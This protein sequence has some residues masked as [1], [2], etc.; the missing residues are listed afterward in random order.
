MPIPEFDALRHEN[1]LY[2]TTVGRKTGKPRTIEIWFVSYEERL[3]LL[4]EHGLKAQW[5]RNIQANPDVRM[6]IARHRFRARGR[7]L[8]AAQDEN[9]VGAT[10]CRSHSM[11]VRNRDWRIASGAG[12]PRKQIERGDSAARVSSPEEPLK[13]PEAFSGT[14]M[15]IAQ[16]AMNAG[17]TEILCV[18]IDRRDTWGASTTMWRQENLERFQFSG[19]EDHS[20][21]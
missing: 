21:D 18:N 6:Q 19:H 5:V 10:A 3:Y 4:A 7:I 8:D 12:R 17:R 14:R 2:L 13:S 1:V 11:R 15:C 9:T 16:N 20:R